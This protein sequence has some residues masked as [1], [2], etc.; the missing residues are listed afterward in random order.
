[1]LTETDS[2]RYKGDHVG[3]WPFSYTYYSIC[4]RHRTTI[5][6]CHLCMAGGYTND[7]KHMVMNFIYTHNY[8]LWYVLVN[9]VSIGDWNYNVF[10]S[11]HPRFWSL[12]NTGRK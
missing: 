10:K 11:L 5:T 8:Q 2:S 3:T 4:S 7:F 6:D 12:K 9:K 1:M